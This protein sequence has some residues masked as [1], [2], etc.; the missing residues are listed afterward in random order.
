MTRT[1]LTATLAAGALAAPAA[2]ASAPAPNTAGYVKVATARQQT[3]DLAAKTAR[4]TGASR[5]STPFCRR[6]HRW[7][8]FCSVT[9]SYPGDVDDTGQRSAG[10]RVRYVGETRATRGGWWTILRVAKPYATGLVTG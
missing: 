1:I 2:Q 8:V 7:Q 10:D 6:A 3:A 4:R 9:I 5:V